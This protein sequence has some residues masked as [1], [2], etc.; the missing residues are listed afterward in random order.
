MGSIL[1]GYGVMVVFLIVANAILWT[2]RCKWHYVTMN[3]LEQKQLAVAATHNL[4]AAWVVAG[5]GIFEYLL[6]AQ[7]SVSWRKFH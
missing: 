6:K 7:V 1:S 5:G 4:V 2:V 3:H